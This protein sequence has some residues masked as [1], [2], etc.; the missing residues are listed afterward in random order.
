MTRQLSLLILTLK[1]Q[2]IQMVLMSDVQ[3]DLKATVEVEGQEARSERTK[4]QSIKTLN[5]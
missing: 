3:D 1:I 5:D 2:R 4:R